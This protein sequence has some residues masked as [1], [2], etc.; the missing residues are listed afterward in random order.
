MEAEK[1]YHTRYRTSKRVGN[2]DSLTL[3]SVEETALLGICSDFVAPLLGPKRLLDRPFFS[4]TYRNS[5]FTLF[6][7]ITQSLSKTGK[8][9][10][11]VN[12]QEHLL[13]V[14]RVWRTGTVYAHQRVTTPHSFPITS[15]EEK[16]K[17]DKK[18]NHKSKHCQYARKRQEASSHC[19]KSLHCTRIGCRAGSPVLPYSSSNCKS[20]VQI[21]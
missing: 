9:Y 16:I 5:G 1:R 2:K 13:T 10:N 21:R 18:H 6:V 12:L 4:A 7:M 11:E 17:A 19:L 8:N 14:H 3:K 15:K 20:A